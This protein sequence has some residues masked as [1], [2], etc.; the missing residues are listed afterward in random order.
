M[1][2]YLSLTFAIYLGRWIFSAFAMFIPLYIINKYKWTKGLK[3]KEYID[4]VLI[5]IAGAFF[6]YKID[7]WIFN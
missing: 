4:L 1:T 6:F 2:D 3:Y 5:Q 7:Q